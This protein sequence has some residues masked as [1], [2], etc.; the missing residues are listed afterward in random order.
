[1]PECFYHSLL[2]L[3]IARTEVTLSSVTPK[4]QFCRGETGALAVD[5][6]PQG[7]RISCIPRP[8]LRAFSP[9]CANPDTAP[10][11]RPWSQRET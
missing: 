5:V 1:M 11:G 9:I 10:G 7:H 3:A 2:E 8:L 6:L 4:P